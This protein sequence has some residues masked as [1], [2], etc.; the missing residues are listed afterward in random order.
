MENKNFL[1]KTLLVS[2]VIIIVLAVVRYFDLS[3]PL[4][5]SNSSVSSELSVVGEGKVE[6]SP[7]TAYVDA[8]ITV[9]NAPT[10]DTAQKELN[11]KNNAIV[12]A[13]KKLGIKK[14]DIKTSNYSIYP[15]YNYDN[16][17]N[18]N[19]IN[20]Y[21]GN[22]TVSIR[23]KDVSSTSTV[24]VEVTKAGANQI[25]GTRFVVDKPEK[26]REDAR[27]KAIANAKEQAQKLAK[28]LG[29]RL[30]RVTNIVE[31][32]GAPVYSPQYA[33]KSAAPM[34]G[35][36][37]GGSPDI[38]PGSQTISSIVTLYFEKK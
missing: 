18:Q 10:V 28:N 11:D 12:D 17:K 25:Q 29:I 8:G 35:G 32:V 20:G 26:Y 19:R 7:D 37:G 27:D 4:S 5:I 3:Y 31:S 9:D 2:L 30:G 36:M 6:V 14:E 21:N 23:L 16:S 13:V 24:I 15:N 22:V 34:A 1:V 38:E 33:L